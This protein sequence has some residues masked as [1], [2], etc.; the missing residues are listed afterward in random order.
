MSNKDV[1][2]DVHV[3]GFDELRFRAFADDSDFGR[4]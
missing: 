4:M 3:P 1:E 2:I